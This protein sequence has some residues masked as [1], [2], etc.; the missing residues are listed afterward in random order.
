MEMHQIRYFLSVCDTLNFT[1]AADR[2][3]VAQPSLTRAIK[4]LEDEL[5]GLLFWRE[6]RS[7]HLTELGRLMKPHLERVHEATH[8][9]RS[10]A[11]SYREL[12]LAPLRIGVMSSLSPKHFVKFFKR[13]KD[14]IRSLDLKLVVAA[15]N[16]IVESMRCGDIDMAFLG[17]TNL[18][19]RFIAQ[20]VFDEAYRVA[21]P[22]AHILAGNDE[23]PLSALDRQSCLVPVDF[24]DSQAATLLPSGI[25][26]GHEESGWIQAAA[27]R[28]NCCALVP[29]SSLPIDGIVVRPVVMPAPMRT[30]SLVTYAG[31]KH[32]P[33]VALAVKMARRHRWSVSAEAELVVLQPRV[34][35]ATLAA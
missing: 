6:R 21:C 8:S 22:R 5:G 2:C 35:D 31:R 18:P 29:Q 10:D 11:A 9:A 3:H 33:A 27:L 12:D 17:S 23:V 14:E 19:P 28:E 26:S 7:T 15:P 34:C 24:L 4:K 13:I 20:A 30:V 16:A 25:G 32:T 1:R